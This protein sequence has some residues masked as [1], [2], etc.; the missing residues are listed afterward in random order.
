MR[1]GLNQFLLGNNENQSSQMTQTTENKIKN[2]VDSE[3]SEFLKSKPNVSN[4]KSSRENNYDNDL[5]N[6]N[7]YNLNPEANNY[8]QQLR[9]SLQQYSRH[10]QIS[11]S[12][13]KINNSQKSLLKINPKD[14]FNSR[15]QQPEDSSNTNLNS[16]SMHPNNY[17]PLIK[18]CLLYTSD[19]ADEE[20]TVTTKY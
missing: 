1:N 18:N 4:I 7:D 3:L 8:P 15:K 11:N 10:S 12:T 6:N 13:D 20:E 14:S 2:L 5:T 19:A 9:E 17:Q 16:Q